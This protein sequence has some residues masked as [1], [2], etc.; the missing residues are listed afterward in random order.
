MS[1]SFAKQQISMTEMKDKQIE[2]LKS[3]NT[4]L[5]R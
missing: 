2:Q 5:D 1:Q 4:E 3:Q